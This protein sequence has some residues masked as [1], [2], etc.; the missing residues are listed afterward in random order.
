MARPADSAAAR[1]EHMLSA[2]RAAGFL[3]V[4]ALARDLGVSDMTVRRDLRKLAASGHARVVHGGASLPPGALEATEFETR[5]DVN[6]EGKRRVALAA[7]TLID[8]RDTIAIDAGT[9]AYQL[10]AELP[11]GFTGCVV[12]HSVPVI[13][14][15]LARPNMRLVG[16]GGDLYRASG[17]F[18][19]P[20]T[21][22]AA[23]R[24]RLR[25]FFLGAGALDVRGVYVAGDVERPTKQ[26][27]MDIADNVVLLADSTKFSTSAPV[28]LCG[29]DQVTAVVTD[30]APDTRLA[31]ALQCAGTRLIVAGAN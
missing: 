3:S 20:M 12:T 19:G 15:M 4:T 1:R 29:L 17:A 7:R 9:T 25:T 8:E 13:Q 21:V 23:A 28:L 18:V 10:A 27:L 30:E 26:A 5:A 22:D 31:A 6:I 14:L 24:L 16:L 2:L 11:E